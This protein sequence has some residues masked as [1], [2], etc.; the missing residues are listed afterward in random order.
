MATVQ[1]CERGVQILGC[2]GT[3]A[4]QCMAIDFEVLAEEEDQGA[5]LQALV[6]PQLKQSP[7]SMFFISNLEYLD[8]SGASVLIALIG[9]PPA[10]R[11]VLLRSLRLF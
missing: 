1:N 10:W 6:A 4:G 8:S 9:A 2:E 5:A 7:S 11:S 3:L